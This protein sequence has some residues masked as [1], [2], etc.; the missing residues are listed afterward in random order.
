MG[1]VAAELAF[2]LR[3]PIS[4]AGVARI[5][6]VGA[7]MGGMAA[8]A[9]LR[10]QGHDVTVLEQ[11][12][13]YGGKLARYERDGFVF[14]TGPSLFTLPAVYRD[15]F[16]KT[17]SALEDAVDLQ[18]LDTAFGYRFGDGSTLEV[19]GVDPG[20]I[21]RAMGDQLGG[22]AAD[23]WRALMARAG[24]VWRITRGPFLQ[25]PL[26]GAGTL[27]RLATDPREVRAVAPFTSLRSLGRKH[28]KDQRQV[29]LL[30]RYA[31]YQG[32]DPR[33]APAALMTVPYVEQTFGA[34][35][36]GGGVATLADALAARCAERGVTIRMSVDVSRVLTNDSGVTGVQ[37]ADGEFIDA[38]IVVA[39]CDATHLYAHMVDDARGRKPLRRASRAT[40]SLAG[41]V[42]LLAVRG[43]TEGLQHH[44]VW[45]PQD[46]DAEFDAVFGGRPVA[47]PTIYVCAPDDPRMR[48]D[49]D[50][51][52]WFVLV[53]APRNGPVDWD[54]LRESYA[55]HILEVMARRG[56]DVRDRVLW[57]EIRTPADLERSARAPGG[58]IYG[59]SS[60][61]TRAAF[62]RPANV[63]PIPGL[64][65]VGGSAHPG[66]G[67]PL[68][69]ISAKI[70]A[71]AVGRS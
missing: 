66:G 24:E 13:T 28:L 68:V 49:A 51:E 34:W 9:R 58:S 50:H 57:H 12:T 44:N 46:Y 54:S 23:D 29:A 11:G 32:S 6:V 39:N 42:L 37:L 33:K 2:R 16:L 70:V 14:D 19:P 56:F 10:V 20:R 26:E 63:S 47:D 31:T 38:D 21:A 4:L 71:E 43:R 8:A 45:F 55:D 27:M 59:T 53:N 48:P 62:L 36:L 22:T 25:S 61:G 65:L 1:V 52:S 30:D 7:G 64:Y 69:G 3:P 5:A 40:P 18:L 17:G 67:L 60:N 35:H 41:F 15:L